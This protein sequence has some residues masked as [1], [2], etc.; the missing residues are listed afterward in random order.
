MARATVKLD[1]QL[2]VLAKIDKLLADRI[3][4]IKQL[5]LAT[6]KEMLKDFQSAQYNATKE[7]DPSRNH[8]L[9]ETDWA[10]A[11]AYANEHDNDTMPSKRQTWVNW[12]MRAAR[13]VHAYIEADD[14]EIV[15]G[16]RHT[17][18]YGAYLEYANN[19]KYAVLEP[20]IRK[21]AP[22]LIK[23]CKAIMGDTK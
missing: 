7:D 8:A 10:A 4:L 19:R 22:Q 13:G 15:L 16:L 18:P 14:K 2:Q 5:F 11:I 17:V 1:N 6:G 12:S 9:T 20:M 23:D 3:K 21:Y